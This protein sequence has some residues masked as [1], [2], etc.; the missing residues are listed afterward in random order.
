M[1]IG[2]PRSGDL[3][4]FAGGHD[5]DR[6]RDEDLHHAAVAPGDRQRRWSSAARRPQRPAATP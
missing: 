4:C 6:H 5:I 3:G 1:F 2:Q